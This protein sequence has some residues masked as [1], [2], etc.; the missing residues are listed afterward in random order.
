MDQFLEPPR[1]NDD[2]QPEI[3][4]RMPG[5]SNRSFI[6][7]L[8]YMRSG[9]SLTGDILQQHPGSFYI[10][11]PLH[12]TTKVM[13]EGQ[14][15]FMQNGQ[16]RIYGMED[17]KE[18]S[19]DIMGSFSSCHVESLSCTLLGDGLTIGK[20]HRLA[21][22]RECCRL[23]DYKLSVCPP[24]I[25][26]QILKTDCLDS[27]YIVIKT[28]RLPIDGM[29]ELLEKNPNMKIIHLLRDPR[30]T[31]RS[32]I[33]YGVGKWNDI[34]NVSMNWCQRV[35]KDIETFE[36]FKKKFP[37]RLFRIRYEDLSRYPINISRL[38]YNFAGIQYTDEVR[39]YVYSRMIQP[40]DPSVPG[41]KGTST[42][43][44]EK[45]RKIIAWW[46]VKTIDTNCQKVYDKVGYRRARDKETL[47]DLTISMTID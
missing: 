47:E 19:Q 30:A 4:A 5:F 25:C 40:N 36:I 16:A 42:D 8:T 21:N 20:G 35:I 43:R 17:L 15:I 1:I 26:L 10:F 32:E 44:M 12:R 13:K 29:E 22:Y 46:A 38:M 9:S 31:I 18:V 33:S 3:T 37:N 28:I 2:A 11:E 34:S 27:K 14:P 7:I 6:V 23:S 45:W 41:W 24:A 39:Q